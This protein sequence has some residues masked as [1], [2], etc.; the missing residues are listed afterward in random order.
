M[1][2]GSLYD[3][4]W[5]DDLRAGYGVNTYPSGDV[6]KGEYKNGFANGRG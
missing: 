2:D 6:Y 5:D 1:A 4:E 3:G